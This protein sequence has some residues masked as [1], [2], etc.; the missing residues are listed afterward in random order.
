ME[1]KKVNEVG[2]KGYA[3]K[4]EISK[5][6]VKK[7]TPTKWLTASATGLVTLLYTSPKNSIHKIGI[8]FG[9]ISIAGEETNNYTSFW[10][11]TNSIMDVFYYASWILGV[12]FVLLLGNHMV[13]KKKYDED[14][15]LKSIKNIK[16][17]ATIF[18]VC[19]IIT[20]LLVIF[21]K[22][23]LD[24]FYEQTNGVVT[25]NLTDSLKATY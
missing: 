11:I 18:I 1:L 13:N 22:L 23:D 10:H 4:D 9:C 7:F 25:N 2:A 21:L 3:K 16:I 24:I 15:R 14:K 20:V 8:V 5:K 17:L 19:V 6:E 12:A